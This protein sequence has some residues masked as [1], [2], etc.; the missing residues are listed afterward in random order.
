MLSFI[1]WASQPLLP[2]NTY[3]E[4]EIIRAERGHG[5]TP[6]REERPDNRYS[7]LTWNIGY[8]SGLTNNQAANATDQENGANLDALTG[9]LQHVLPDIAA[10]QEVDFDSRRSYSRD[11]AKHLAQWALFEYRAVAYNWDTR[12]VPFPYWPPKAHFARVLSGQAVLSGH[13]VESQRVV[14]FPKPAERSSWYNAF[15]PDRLAQVVEVDLDGTP[16][17]VINVHLEAYMKGTRERQAAQ[18]AQLA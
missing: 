10:L 8:A 12:Y 17:T 4:G 18:V 3:R 6:F 9:L 5:R 14:A 13:P 16:V 1:G 7:I 11:Q 15:Y 2:G